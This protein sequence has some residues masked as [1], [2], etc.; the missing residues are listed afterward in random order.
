MQ[1]A[2]SVSIII[3]VPNIN[4]YILESAPEILKLDWPDYEIIIFPDE[5]D[6]SHSWPKTRIIA[7]GKVGPAEKRDLALKYAKGDILA[8]LDDDAYPEKSWLTKAIIHF[9]DRDV[10]A[11]G[12]PAITPQNDSFMQKVSGSVWESYV[13]GW[14]ARNRNLSLGEAR[15]VDDWPTVNFLIRKEVFKEI[16]GFDSAYWPGEDTKLCLDIL[17]TG[18]RIVYE[19]KAIVYHHRRASLVKHFRQIG[20]YGL[21]RGF[22]TKRYPANSRKIG[23]LAVIFYDCY[24][25]LLFLIII[26]GRSHPLFALALGLPLTIYVLATIFDGIIISIRRKNFFMGLLTAPLIISTHF[27][28]GV[29]YAQGLI[30]KNLE[31]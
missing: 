16:G 13:G 24:L 26:F 30:I 20:N 14:I 8:F 4:D 31:R 7:S 28:Y 12:G 6:K 5:E 9:S 3:P 10:A 1:E 17:E 29:R 21:H 27:W 25:L 19:P 22:F 23:Y 15:D 11:V 2:A 18:R